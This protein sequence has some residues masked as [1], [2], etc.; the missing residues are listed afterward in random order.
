M[1]AANIINGVASPEDYAAAR[2]ADSS[3]WSGSAKYTVERAIALAEEKFDIIS[4]DTAKKPN[5]VNRKDKRKG[6]EKRQPSGARQRNVA[7]PNGEEHSRVP[8]GNGIRREVLPD[9]TEVFY[10]VTTAAVVA[11]IVAGVIYFGPA[12]AGA[13]VLV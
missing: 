13:L 2:M 10:V 6:S 11:I 12:M 4:L 1:W 5:F 7:H 3:A 9:G 8:K